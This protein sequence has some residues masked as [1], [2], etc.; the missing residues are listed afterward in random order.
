[1]RTKEFIGR[2]SQKVT[3]QG[4][5]INGAMWRVLHR[6]NK[7]ERSHFASPF[8]DGCQIVDG[9]YGVRSI[10]YCD[11]PGTRR[12]F[13]AQVFHIQCAGGRVNIG[14]LDDDAA[15]LKGQ[16][17]RNVGIVIEGGDENLVAWL[18]DTT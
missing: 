14:S 9:A 8:D 10:A 13:G 18:K 5:H 12:E 6:V 17:G 7:D 15:L 4:A 11:Q 16:P 1:M 3:V 2:T